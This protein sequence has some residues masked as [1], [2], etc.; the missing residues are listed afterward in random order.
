MANYTSWNKDTASDARMNRMT[1][2]PNT[3][4]VLSGLDKTLHGLLICTS[5]GS[6]LTANHVYLCSADG[7]SLIDVSGMADHAHTTGDGGKLVS[8]YAAN[9]NT[10]DLWLT[11]TQDLKR[12]NWIETTTGTATIADNTD[13]TT[14]ERS[15]RLLP[16]A[17]SGSGATISYPHLQLKFGD[18]AIFA[19][20][21]R[22]E[23]ASSLAFHSGVGADDIT[24]ADSNTRKF[25][26]E[27]CTA[28]NNNF[29]LRTATGSANSASD[30]G[31]AFSTSRV[32]IRIVHDP[33]GTPTTTLYI[34]T[35]SAFIKSSNIPIDG[36]TADNNII[37]HSIKNSTAADRPMHTYGSR[38]SFR[39]SDEWVN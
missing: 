23:T 29:W 30:S 37:K 25:N 4:A 6:G 12:A 35:S 8:I 2:I 10:C 32:G 20:K 1:V 19:T 7:T 24:A 3:G 18:T 38:V 16:G 39:I 26:V 31:I 15:I 5:S 11:K 21:L 14:G 36:T 22:I 33:S 27:V 34:D 13:G 17:T 9:A 28:N